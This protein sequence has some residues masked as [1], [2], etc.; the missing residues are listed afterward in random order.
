MLVKFFDSGSSRGDSPINYL[1]GK[2]RDR[3]GATLLLGDPDLM[4]KVINAT[5]FAKKYTSGVLSFSEDR[6]SDELV[7]EIIID[8]EELVFP[9]ISRAEFS[10]LWVKH[11]DK[12]RVE[13]H[14]VISTLNM[15]SGKRMQPYYFGQD[16]KGIDAW[17]SMINIRHKLS[18]PD[19][20][21]R[22]QIFSRQKRLPASIRPVVDDVES[23]IGAAISDGVIE[24]RG[25]VVNRLQ[26]DGYSVLRIESRYVSVLSRDGS[27][28]IRLRS[29]P[30]RDGF[31]AK[32][33]GDNKLKSKSID[34]HE[35]TSERYE[36]SLAALFEHLKRKVAFNRARHPDVLKNLSPLKKIGFKYILN[37]SMDGI[38]KH[39]DHEVSDADSGRIDAEIDRL[40]WA[41]E[42][43]IAELKKSIRELAESD[44]RAR[45]IILGRTDELSYSVRHFEESAG[46]LE[47][48]VRKLSAGIKAVADV[49]SGYARS[50]EQA[51]IKAFGRE[52][53]VDVAKCS[54]NEDDDLRI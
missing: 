50:I 31:Y 2:G 23:M 30:F 28:C 10:F 33:V 26:Q 7:F 15:L 22:R 12:G 14:F 24:T 51:F 1:L 35:R 17:R 45:A 48:S 49:F 21:A 27:K 32:E 37:G 3:Q 41:A 46:W 11:E 25:D 53:S 20:P 16:F 5:P 43:R 47:E 13:L 54:I 44:E 38:E 42:S 52:L 18:D 34:F 8:F 36:K 29:R 40:M 19:D 6:I 4:I 9:G 39:L